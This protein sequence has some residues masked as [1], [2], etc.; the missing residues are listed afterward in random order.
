[1]WAEQ[2][3]GVISL[4]DCV[5]SA[6]FNFFQGATMHTPEEKRPIDVT[7][8]I[9]NLQAGNHPSLA[10][11]RLSD[12]YFDRLAR[13]INKQFQLRGKAT[14]EDVANSALRVVLDGLNRGDYHIP[15]G[16]ERGRPHDVLWRLLLKVAIRKALNKVRDEARHDGQALREADMPAGAEGEGSGLAQVGGQDPDPALAIEIKHHCLDLLDL[17][18]D[19]QRQIVALKEAG[20]THKE[21][22]ARQQCSVRT[23]EEK[24][25]QVRRI[26]ERSLGDLA[27]VG[28]V[29]PHD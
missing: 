28:K 10:C 3:N 9:G 29:V 6:Q 24:V 14:E 15:D 20:Y 27:P 7:K 25:G 19:D 13:V 4:G 1:M 16:D 22:A 2:W 8:E 18:R 17:L 5:P 23:V 26:W 21:I 11:L 12:Y